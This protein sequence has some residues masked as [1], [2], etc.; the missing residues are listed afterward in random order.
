VLVQ[1]WN[2]SPTNGNAYFH[3]ISTGVTATY[4]FSAPAGTMLQGGSV[5]WIVERPTIDGSYSTLMN[6][7]DVPWVEGIAW[8]WQASHPTYYFIGRNPPSNTLAVITMVEPTGC[9]NNCVG[10]SFPTIMNTDFLWLQDGGPAY[11]P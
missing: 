11:K 3:N 2:T 7:I 10:I 4:N 1:V 9:T 8:N 6:Y 5:E